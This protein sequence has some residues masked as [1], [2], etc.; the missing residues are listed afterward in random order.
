MEIRLFRLII[1]ISLISAIVFGLLSAI[2]YFN[3]SET[4]AVMQEMYQ[5]CENRMGKNCL[6]N[7]NNEAIWTQGNRAEIF[8]A[9]AIGIPTFLFII[10][11]AGQFVMTGRMGKPQAERPRSDE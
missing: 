9:C 6:D 3:F 1:V 5:I 2:N 11:F 4:T 8:I 10:F 7:L